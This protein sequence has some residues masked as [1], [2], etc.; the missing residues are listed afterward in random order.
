MSK[1]TRPDAW[2]I[3]YQNTKRLNEMKKDGR[4]NDS[5]YQ[6]LK[7]WTRKLYKEALKS[8]KLKEI[9]KILEK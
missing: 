4:I 2:K 7:E 9:A 5:D 3:Q 1:K 6:F 8:E